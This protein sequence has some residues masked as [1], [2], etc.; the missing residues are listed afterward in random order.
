MNSGFFALLLRDTAVLSRPRKVAPISQIGTAA[1]LESSSHINTLRV[2]SD[3]YTLFNPQART[4]VRSQVAHGNHVSA[5]VAFY[6]AQI[7]SLAVGF[8]EGLCEEVSLRADRE[9]S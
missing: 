7:A 5:K 3:L 8:M 9:T 4:E 6:V 1:Q 2:L